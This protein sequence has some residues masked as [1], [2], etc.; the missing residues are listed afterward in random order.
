M[1]LLHTSLKKAGDRVLRGGS[2]GEEGRRKRGG[3][4]EE[5][6][7]GRK[8]GGTAH[9]PDKFHPLPSHPHTLT[10]ITVVSANVTISPSNL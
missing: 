2:E 9:G 10:L 3:G 5:E 4:R 8:A 6:A 7:G 1:N